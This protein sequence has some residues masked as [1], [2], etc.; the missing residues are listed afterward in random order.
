MEKT[1]G[2]VRVGEIGFGQ[3]LDYLKT[4][5]QVTDGEI[6]NSVGAVPSLVCRWRSGERTLDR[7][8]D[9]H[10]VKQLAAFFIERAALKRQSARMAE[11]LLLAETDIDAK[12]VI[13]I[14]ALVDFLY[15]GRGFN[16]NVSTDDLDSLLIPNHEGNFIGVQGVIDAL[17]LLEKR[18]QD[19]PQVDITVYLSLEYSRLLLD[20]AA[21]GIWDLLYC[22]NRNAPVRVVF[23][24]WLDNAEKVTQNLK[25][26][27]PFMQTDK[28][29]LHM[30][31]STQKF[32]Y[33]NLTFFAKGA[34]MVIT[35]EPAGS[36]GVSISLL[37]ATPDYV[38]GM[39]AV[40]ADIDRMSKSL[41]RHIGGASTKDEAVYYGRL[42]E[43]TEDVQA[44]SG[45]LNLLYLDEESYLS[46][47]KQNGIKGSQRGY[48]H[49]KFIEDKRRFATFLQEHRLK[50]IISLPS[51][52]R[53]IAENKIKTPD[54]S[55]HDG[56]IK[57]DGVILK[58]LITGLLWYIEQYENLSV[59]LERGGGL[60][61]DFT[62]RIK[63]D[64][65]VLLHTRENG[66]T[67]M[68]YSDN[69]MLTYEYIKQ[70]QEAL[71]SEPLMNTKNA[72][73]AAL[74]IRLEKLG[75]M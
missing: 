43:P 5:L 49:T 6:G 69:W 41:A 54:F 17:A 42:F 1:K 31:K 40:F 61:Q 21:S 67:H 73:K 70:F 15:D 59:Y 74:Q 12:S 34:G 11:I 64:S 33:Y 32:F 14:N 23:D 19:L 8:K 25:A 44:L 71:T 65:F 39:G 68:V 58:S 10:T 51:L 55:F 27:L 48:R 26:L 63:G 29:Q 3:K 22:M 37:A 46:L 35:T 20:E 30:I 72:V 16:T 66:K 2:G 9:I 75:G 56:E 57:A 24:G 47:L 4:M 52:D 13:G 45:V 18:L 53:M 7:N 38:S 36:V 50:E 60:G 28:I 62:C